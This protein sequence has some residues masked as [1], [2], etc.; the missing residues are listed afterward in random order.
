[1]RLAPTHHICILSHSQSSSEQSFGGTFE[2]PLG[3]ETGR[4]DLRWEGDGSNPQTHW[5]TAGSGSLPRLPR[6]C[7]TSNRKSLILTSTSPTLPRP[8]SPLPGHLGK[9]GDGF[10]GQT[11]GGGAIGKECVHAT[12]GVVKSLDTE[13][14]DWTRGGAILV[15][16]RRFRKGT[17]ICVRRP[18][19]SLF[20]KGMGQKGGAILKGRG[21]P[22]K[23]G[24]DP[25]RGW[26]D[27]VAKTCFGEG[28]QLR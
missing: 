24:I 13:D 14:L 21:S 7:R 23:G 25:R 2:H 27:L 19:R 12:G 28:P 26:A 1:M 15:W 8:H 18:R 6:S 16:A 9:T 10:A 5:A 11:S 22:E 4:R 17:G 3:W 20:G